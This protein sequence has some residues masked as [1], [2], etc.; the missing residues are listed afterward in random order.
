LEAEIGAWLDAHPLGVVIV[1][2]LSKVRPQGKSGLNAYDEDYAAITELHN[3]ARRHPGSVILLITHD[4]KAGSEDWMT[5]ITGTRGVT[6]AADFVIFID[7]K[8]TEMV[9]TIFVTGRDIEDLAHDVQFTGSGWL[10]A[11]IDLVIGTKSPI[12]QTIFTWVKENGPAWQ[13]AIA[14][15]TGVEISTIHA[16]VF[17]MARDGELIGGPNGYEVRNEYRLARARYTHHRKSRKP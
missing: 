6:G 16:R 3:V 5:R 14:D 13:K 8:R 9:G 11:S 17:D 2:V 12:R 15:G 4:R 7:R 10:P 1:D